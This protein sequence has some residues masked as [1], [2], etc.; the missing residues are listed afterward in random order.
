M[1]AVTAICGDG[2]HIGFAIE[3]GVWYLDWFRPH[4]V[5]MDWYLGIRIGLDLIAWLWVGIAAAAA[6]AAVSVGQQY[7]LCTYLVNVTYLVHTWST[8]HTLYILWVDTTQQQFGVFDF[9]PYLF[10]ASII[11]CAFP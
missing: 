3:Y 10:L 11:R 6:A 5:V 9:K 7:I 8:V 1:V 4:R 2:I